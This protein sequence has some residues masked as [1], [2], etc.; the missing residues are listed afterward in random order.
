[1]AF[2]IV[3]YRKSSPVWKAIIT[4]FIHP[5]VS[6]FFVAFMRLEK[7]SGRRRHPFYDHLDAFALELSM[8]LFKRFL[9]VNADSVEQS[10]LLVVLSGFEEVTMRAT[11]E[12]REVLIRKLTR[13]RSLSPN[14]LRIKRAVI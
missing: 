14:E 3:L 5:V 4:L 9:F 2:T 12:S 11:L 1:M 8:C 7:G 13:K 6:E 10:I